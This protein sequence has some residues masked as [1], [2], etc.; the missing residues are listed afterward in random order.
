M[1][2]ATCLL[3][4]QCWTWLLLQNNPYLPPR[5][6]SSLFV[7]YVFDP[8]I[9]LYINVFHIEKLDNYC[10]LFSIYSFVERQKMSSVEQKI[11]IYFS[12]EISCHEIPRFLVSHEE[13]GSLVRTRTY[14]LRPNSPALLTDPLVL[15]G[16]LIHKF[17]WQGFSSF[18]VK[19][20]QKMKKNIFMKI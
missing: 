15:Y 2:Q 19:C 1:Q 18:F 10:L 3:Y 4:C 17:T 6:T 16:W 5:S 14:V 7:I 9:Q 8:E 13:I 11:T 20:L 12:W